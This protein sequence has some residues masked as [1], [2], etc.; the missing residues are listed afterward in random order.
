MKLKT[1]R[2]QRHP[3]TGQWNLP[4]CPRELLP[5]VSV[6]LDWLE[7]NPERGITGYTSASQLDKFLMTQWW[8]RRDGMQQAIEQSDAAKFC[9]WFIK[10]ATYPDIIKSA[11]LWLQRNELVAIPEDIKRDGKRKHDLLQRSFGRDYC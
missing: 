5:T 6:I 4:D 8:L 1:W 2:V 10:H 11:R 9:E 7:A 3:R